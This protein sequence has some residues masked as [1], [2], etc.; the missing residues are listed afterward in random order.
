MVSSGLRITSWVEHTKKYNSI[1]WQWKQVC[2]TKCW[3]SESFNNVFFHVTLV[4][5]YGNKILLAWTECSGLKHWLTNHE[6]CFNWFEDSSDYSVGFTSKW[7]SRFA[8]YSEEGTL[9]AKTMSKSII[10]LCLSGRQHLMSTS[11]ICPT[12]YFALVVWQ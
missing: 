2:E 12:I 8:K 7:M 5:Q 10:Q 11:V 1:N 6:C 4:L 9:K 3:L